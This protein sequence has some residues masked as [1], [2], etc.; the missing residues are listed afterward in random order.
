[1]SPGGA[2]VRRQL[3]GGLGLGLVRGQ[4][5]GRHVEAVLEDVADAGLAPDRRALADQVGD[6]AIDSAFG[7]LQFLGD[8]QGGDGM[9]TPSQDLD[10]L[11][12]AVGAARRSSCQAADR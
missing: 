7:D 9:A 5:Q 6:V 1:M 2:D 11:E 8:G 3:F 12:Q 4:H 10:D